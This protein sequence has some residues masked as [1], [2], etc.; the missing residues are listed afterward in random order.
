[1]EKLLGTLILAWTI[2]FN[3]FYREHTKSSEQNYL[4]FIC[5]EYE[6]SSNGRVTVRT[7]RKTKNRS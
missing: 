7:G 6:P 4:G 2:E 5:G 3:T 1:M